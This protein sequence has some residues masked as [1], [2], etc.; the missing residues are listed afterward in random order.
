MKKAILLHNDG[1]VK[2]HSDRTVAIC[3]VYVVL[4]SK[5]LYN[6]KVVIIEDTFSTSWDDFFQ[7]KSMCKS[8]E[9]T[10]I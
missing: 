2:I 5:Y 10:L 6:M 4:S 1:L 8:S 7:I 9:F 3:A